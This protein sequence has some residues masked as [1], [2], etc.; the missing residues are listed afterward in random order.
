MNKL[1]IIPFICLTLISCGKKKEPEL[2]PYIETV[3]N[4]SISCHR[5]VDVHNTIFG[6]EYNPSTIWNCSDGSFE[7]IAK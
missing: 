4:E 1:F 6:Q 2:K 7:I 5:I 3:S